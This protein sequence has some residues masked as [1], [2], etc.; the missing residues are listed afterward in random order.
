MT[1]TSFEIAPDRIQL[2]TMKEASQRLRVSR[3]TLY[4]LIH[5]QRL[6][7]VKIGRRR[8]VPPEALAKLIAELREEPM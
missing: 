2:L 8:L 5:R 6:E 7:T 1:T 3:S 4:D